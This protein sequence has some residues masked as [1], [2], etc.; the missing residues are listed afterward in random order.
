MMTCNYF[1]YREMMNKIFY[2]NALT[3]EYLNN[4]TENIRRY[5]VD[6]GAGEIVKTLGIGIRIVEKQYEFSPDLNHIERRRF[7]FVEGERKDDELTIDEIK[8]IG[9]FLKHGPFCGNVGL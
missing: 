1:E 7:V 5:L 6:G 9:M 8:A 2:G 3:D 4:A